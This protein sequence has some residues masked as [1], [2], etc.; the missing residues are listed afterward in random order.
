MQLTAEQEFKNDG[1]VSTSGA[2]RKETHAERKAMR[3]QRDLV[4][5]ST[6]VLSRFVLRARRLQ[7]HSLMQHPVIMNPNV[8]EHFPPGGFRRHGQFVQM[9]PPEEAF[10]SLVA[11]L[12]PFILENDGIN[13]GVALDL[14]CRVIAN[15]GTTAYGGELEALETRWRTFR[16]EASTLHMLG[17]NGLISSKKL[18]KAWLYTESVHS[19]EGL[20]RKY[21]TIPRVSL[22]MVAVSHYA[23][24]ANI[25]M[26]TLD[27][28]RKVSDAGIIVL[29]P[30][31]FQEGVTVE[32]SPVSS[33]RGA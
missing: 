5:R 19:D 17:P 31:S 14:L 28:A 12:R 11:R 32:T 22:F 16:S 13:V 29:P 20:H 21:G 30:H 2:I 15:E 3:I 24:A 10:E 9:L 1:P 8:H 26:A 6:H 23:T 25:V 33:K 7:A 18:A 27:L 4:A